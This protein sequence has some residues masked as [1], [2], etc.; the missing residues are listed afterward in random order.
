MI[1]DFCGRPI[2]VGQIVVYGVSNRDYPINVGKVLEIKEGHAVS[3]GNKPPMIVIKGFNNA[4]VSRISPHYDEL[5]K[6]VV[7]LDNPPE[8]LVEYFKDD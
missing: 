7:I 5:S 3:Y 8:E 4:R 2:E 6:R 1:K